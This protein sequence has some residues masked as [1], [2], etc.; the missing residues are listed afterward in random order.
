MFRQ[1]SAVT[2]V[3]YDPDGF[4]IVAHD[5]HAADPANRGSI[6]AFELHHQFGFASFPRD[7]EVDPDKQP[8]PGKS[9]DVWVEDVGEDTHGHL[10]RDPRFVELVPKLTGG[11]SCQ[12]S[13]TGAFFLLDGSEDDGTATLYV[14]L[15]GEEKAH[16]VTVGKD[17]A[18]K[19]YLGLVHSD[20]MA[21]TMLDSKIVLKNVD[22]SAY[23]EL[24]PSGHVLSGNTLVR[25]G[26]VCGD[27]AV[28]QPLVN[29][30]AFAALFSALIAEINTALKAKAGGDVL[31]GA[32]SGA[33]LAG[34][35]TTL[36]KGS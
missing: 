12:Y 21:V 15:P 32:G 34:L 31:V 1:L 6:A 30:T 20:G 2:Y 29:F 23:H 16:V 7:P 36:T 22:G 27:P 14:P 8:I 35:A 18:G 25:G 9:C 11:S 24:G 4:P 3:G 10:G 17:A 33:L 28:A 5:S 13:A 19:R 26:F